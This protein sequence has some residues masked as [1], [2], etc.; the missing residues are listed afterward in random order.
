MAAS[1]LTYVAA[2][3][4][5]IVG[6]YDGTQIGF[7]TCPDASASPPVFGSIVNVY[8]GVHDPMA[9]AWV[10]NL[11]DDS[12]DVG[13]MTIGGAGDVKYVKLTKSGSTW[14]VGTPV[15]VYS[16]SSGNNSPACPLTMCRDK[17]GNL[18]M[19]WETNV[20]GSAL[21]EVS[22]SSNGG[23]TW[24]RDIIDLSGIIQDGQFSFIITTVDK[25]VVLLYADQGNSS[26]FH[27]RR[28]DATT[29]TNT[30]SAEQTVSSASA[31]RSS[32]FSAHADGTPKLHLIVSDQNGSNDNANVPDHVYNP[33]TDTWATAVTL[34]GV[35]S[36]NSDASIGGDGTNCWVA[37][38]HHQDTIQYKKFTNGTGWDASWTVLE[39]AAG[40]RNEALVPAVISTGGFFVSWTNGSSNPWTVDVDFVAGSSS[41][42]LTRTAL[43]TVTPIN[44]AARVDAFLRAGTSTRAPTNTATRVE[45]EVRTALSARAPTTTA[46]RLQVLLRTPVSTIAP[47]NTAT[48]LQTLLRSA[49]STIAIANTAARVIGLPRPA[50]ST[51]AISSMATRLISLS[52]N[53]VSTLAPSALALRMAAYLRS[54]ASG[55]SPSTLSTRLIGFLRAALSTV[56]PANTASRLR[57]IPKAAFSTIVIANTAARL[58][59]FFRSGNSTVTP[60]NLGS[61]GGNQTRAAHT[62]IAIANTAARLQTMLRVALST[63]TPST[64]ASRLVAFGRSAVSTITPSNLTSRA[65]GML[66]SGVSILAPQTLATRPIALLR[67]SVSTVAGSAV[68]SRL[69]AYFRAGASTIT[70]HTTGSEMHGQARSASTTVAPQTLAMSLLLRMRQAVSTVAG[71]IRATY[72]IVPFLVRHPI[73]KAA[74]AVGRWFASDAIGRW[75][76]QAK[77]AMFTRQNQSKDPIRIAVS[78]T[79]NGVPVVLGTQPVSI[80]I[81]DPDVDPQPSDWMTGFWELDT[82]VTPTVY[83]ADW[84]PP[85]SWG[86]SFP[87]GTYSAHVQVIDSPDHPVLFGGRVTIY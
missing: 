46:T 32:I 33:S 64:L 3:K 11:S 61:T 69:A 44:T 25:Y 7:K 49:H 14:T 28:K 56:T 8:T 51:I 40:T 38:C 57:N 63:V 45:G 78:G 17:F 24:T 73:W 75:T 21:A 5:G 86:A 34:D 80:A 42:A 36:L 79:Y 20:A 52:R 31:F 30:W 15:T 67:A 85:S 87:N 37:E 62:T 12:I 54:A 22:Y 55:V 29:L 72:S 81:V 59:A 19:A 1:N 71:S 53:A 76:A 18:W 41:A 68:S 77:D 47:T 82:T 48:R 65:L 35:A 60:S 26:A 83:Y 23:T 74:Q 84:E 66:R 58:V 50:L 4:T 6:G 70:P 9:W 39:T 10:P 13:Y 43:S 2:D 27:W 16:P